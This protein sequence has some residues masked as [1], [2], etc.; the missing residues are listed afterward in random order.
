MF[1]PTDAQTSAPERALDPPWALT[2][3]GFV[4]AS[5]GAFV[6]GL[7]LLSRRAFAE[8][9]AADLTKVPGGDATPSLFVSI[10]PTGEVK[11]TC[12]R[13]EM[14]QHVWTS[15]A[16]IVADEMD[17]DWSRISIVQA[18]GHPR[19][20]D[21]NTD[22]S[23]SVRFNLERLRVTGAAMRL[24]LERAAAKRW[25][26]KPSSCEANLHEVV[27]RSTGRRLAYGDLAADAAALDLPK[28]RDVKRRLKP[29]SAWRYIG[30]GTPS[31][32]VPQVVRGQGTFGVDVR[33]PDMAIAVIARP[34]QVFGAAK[35]VDDSE[36]LK[37]AG[38]LKTM[39]MPTLSAPAAFKPLG[40]VAVVATNTW[41]AL[42]GR[43]ALKVEWDAGPNAE[44]ESKAFAES[45]FETIRKPGE[46]RRKRGNVDT[47]LSAAERRL[48]AEYYV[49]HYSQS[50]ME[51]PA[52]TARWTAEDRVELWGCAQTPQRARKMVAL[53]CGIPEDNVTVHVT[54]L[55]GGF[56][57]KSKPDF[58]VEAA[59]IAKD[60]QR[61]VK[62]MWSRED[63]LQHGYYHTVSAQ[64]MEGALDK[65]GRC[66][67][68]LHRTV[69]PPIP[70][71]L[72]RLARHA[73][74]GRAST[75]RVRQPVCRPE[76]SARIGARQSARPHRMA[77]VGRQRL[78]C[79][80]GAKL[81]ERTRRRRGARSER[82]LAGAD[83][84]AATVRPQSRGRQVR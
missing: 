73:F 79:V 65:K 51:P 57:R 61:P 70:V 50:P 18:E 59:L 53:A 75:G 26:V 40:G 21:Q 46:V 36:T 82:L 17:A 68:L 44:Y 20:G 39:K 72:R 19:Y 4:G 84:T 54:W 37:V 29:R 60:A 27:H 80:R 35:T 38:V 1:D 33:L 32:T 81:C 24:M 77:S 23:R 42:Q 12:H 34:P 10:E 2:R 63:D 6:V 8:S 43:K 52:A 3:R 58:F 56:G 45:M 76:S 78:S 5:A 14:G 67:A 49:P 69:F 9:S 83:R 47:A 64:R 25:R 28:L 74:M 71:D 30:K 15:M 13:S 48:E 7:P 22:G 11:I 66:T 16:Q 41:A 31:L 62:V 55:G